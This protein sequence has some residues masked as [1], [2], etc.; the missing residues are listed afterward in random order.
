MYAA[1]KARRAA[2]F[3]QLAVVSLG[4]NDIEIGQERGRELGLHGHIMVS[5][6]FR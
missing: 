5:L 2:V 3:G 4:T 1:W 6:C